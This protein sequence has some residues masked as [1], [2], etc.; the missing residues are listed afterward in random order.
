MWTEKDSNKEK[1]M[2]VVLDEWLRKER[3]AKLSLA[4]FHNLETG[5]NTDKAAR[6][7]KCTN[8]GKNNYTTKD[9]RSKKKKTQL[10]VRLCRRMTNQYARKSTPRRMTTQRIV[11]GCLAVQRG[12]VCLWRIELGGSR[13]TMAV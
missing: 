7:M 8:Y 13:P 12:G 4:K 1:T 2:S 11:R 3:S 9:C 6:S 5:G 10:M